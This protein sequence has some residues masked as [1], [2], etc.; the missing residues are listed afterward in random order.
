MDI[1]VVPDALTSAGTDLQRLGAEVDGMSRAVHSASAG[2]AGAC[3]F[4]DAT[5]ALEDLSSAW[6][7][8]LGRSADGITGLGTAVSV[9]G[10][11]YRLVDL[12]AMDG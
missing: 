3:G 6:S 4:P 9:A 10:A 8:A 1:E 7:G 11:V 12:T 2:A 5:G